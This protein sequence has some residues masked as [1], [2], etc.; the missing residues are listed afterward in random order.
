MSRP[1]LFFISIVCLSLLQFGSLSARTVPMILFHINHIP[2][3]TLDTFQFNSIYVCSVSVYNTFRTN[4]CTIRLVHVFLTPHRR[5]AILPT[6]SGIKNI[7]SN[8]SN[9]FGGYEM[10]IL[11]ACLWIR[12]YRGKPCE[13]NSSE[14]KLS[15][16]GGEHYK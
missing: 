9:Y 2:I 14:A 7:F 3:K 13:Q 6:Q 5:R 16:D 11:C 15:R 1:S 8:A 10:R 4:V 12:E